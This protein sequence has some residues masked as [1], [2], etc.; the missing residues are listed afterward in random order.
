MQREFGQDKVLKK[1][2]KEFFYFSSFFNFN[3]LKFVLS[4]IRE[5]KG[6]VPKRRVEYHTIVEKFR[7][8]VKSM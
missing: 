5:Q 2:K 7:C 3:G 8:K 6:I 4:L 1:K